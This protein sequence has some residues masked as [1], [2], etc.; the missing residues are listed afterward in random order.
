MAVL[1]IVEKDRFIQ[2]LQDEI[3]GNVALLGPMEQS[4]GLTSPL[5]KKYRAETLALKVVEQIL[6][7][8]EVQTTGGT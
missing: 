5:V 3:N 4:M 8:K 6:S 1:T 7:K 2:W